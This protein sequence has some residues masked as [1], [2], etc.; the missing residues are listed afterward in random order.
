MTT[1]RHKVKLSE[2]VMDYD[3]YPR[4]ET[5]PYHVRSM[6]EALTAGVKMPPI[7]VDAKSKRITDGFHRVKA[8]RKFYDDANV[9]V[10]AEVIEY[11]SESDIIAD[12]IR[13]NV[14]HGRAL[15]KHDKVHCIVMLEPF[16]LKP[17]QVAELLNMT[18]D[19]VGEL[20]INRTATGMAS[21]SP[22]ALKRTISH[23]AGK[24][25]TKS[26]QTANSKLSGMNQSFYVRQLL[27]LIRNDLLDTSDER[28]MA[29]LTE[30]HKALE[31]VLCATA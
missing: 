5:D 27:I 24:R 9:M 17:Q 8:Y 25:L 1:K 10:D 7:V 21:R 31:G 19:A 11:K 2:I 14:N 30:L 28:L 20:R 6:V 13:R 16:A 29:E 3:I 15:T 22:I 12:A 18:T 4:S 23:M 26:Q